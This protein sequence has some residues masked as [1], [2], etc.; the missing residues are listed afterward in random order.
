[1]IPAVP[2][3]ESERSAKAGAA[4]KDATKV[5]KS[6]YAFNVSR[7]SFISLGVRTADTSF[8]RLRVW[9][10]KIKLR[11]NEGIWVVPSR[12]GHTFGMLFP[13]DVIYLDAGS[14]VIHLIE[15]LSF[16][17]MA[18]FC[19]QGASILVLPPQSIYGSGTQVGDQLLL[20]TP[21]EIEQYWAASPQP[22]SIRG[23]G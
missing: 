3:I 21:E 12:G 5:P 9:V 4:R 2:F 10:G 1:M 8:A 20:G 14:R 7:Q 18:R 19:R 22:P 17:R 6:L 23:I 13:V 15:R 16:F 11:S